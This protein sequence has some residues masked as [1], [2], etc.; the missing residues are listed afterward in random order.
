MEYKFNKAEINDF[1]NK[2]F[3]KFNGK[4]NCVNKAILIIDWLQHYEHNNGAI[5]R[6]P[7]VVTIYPLVIAR[8]S[9]SVETL[10]YQILI[11]IIHELYHCD[12]DIDYIRS[13]TDKDYIH[14]IESAVEFESNMFIAY[15]RE[16][17]SKEFDIQIIN[18]IESTYGVLDRFKLDNGY[19][20]HRKTYLTH[21]VSIL[22][23]MMHKTDDMVIRQF[24]EAYGNPQSSIELHVYNDIH[25]ILKRGTSVLP[26]SELNAALYNS[27]FRYTH[28][29]ANITMS[30]SNGIDWIMDVKI[31]GYNRLYRL[32]DK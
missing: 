2:V 15:N 18:D 11:C 25:F 5:T 14:G 28:R 1:I 12:Q 3:N 23:D 22:Q 16:W 21:M 8:N 7:N 13:L 31:S 4:I 30:S 26:M 20:Y 9:I 24:I 29:G 10:K 19:C 6:N 27:F 17:L 32:I